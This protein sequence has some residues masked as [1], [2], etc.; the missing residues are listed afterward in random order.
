MKIFELLFVLF[1]TYQGTHAIVSH[2]NRLFSVQTPKSC[3]IYTISNVNW[4]NVYVRMEKSQTSNSV[5]IVDLHSTTTPDTNDQW[6]VSNYT[7]SNKFGYYL[8]FQNVAQGLYMSLS[9]SGC[10]TSQTDSGCG[11]VGISANCYGNE[12]FVY[13]TV[14]NGHHA[15]VSVAN[16][17]YLLRTDG[18]HIVIYQVQQPAA[19]VYSAGA[20]IPQ[21][22]GGGVFN[23]QYYG[24]YR[25]AS[26]WESYDFHL[27]SSTC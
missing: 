14:S 21:Q 9:T 7:A 17:S 22:K 2:R 15:L 20:T 3:S 8:C 13:Q 5:N 6:K 23:A 4:P 1:L 10:T 18:N 27:V 12:Q 24:D 26:S 19:N 11:T 25:T 16:P